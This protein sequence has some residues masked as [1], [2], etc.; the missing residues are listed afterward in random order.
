MP[1]P[2]ARDLVGLRQPGGNPNTSDNNDD[3]S[4]ELGR[5]LIVELGK[6][7]D[8]VGPPDAP[9][10]LAGLTI[11]HLR[12]IRP[13]LIVRDGS[14]LGYAQY[15]HLAVY[16]EFRRKW[17]G[18]RM[19]LAE[20]ETTASRLPPSLDRARME[21]ALSKARASLEEQARLV[22]VLADQ[23]PQESL[24]KLDIAVGEPV[25]EGL[26][27]LHVGLSAKWSLRT[28]RGQDPLS[29][30]SKLVGLRRGRMP[31]F[32]VLTIE[33]R[34]AMLKLLA[35]GSGSIDCIYHLDLAALSRTIETCSAS[36]A[37]PRRWSPKVTFDRLVRQGRIRDYDDLVREVLRIPTIEPGLQATASSP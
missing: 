11:E 32:A 20:L 21:A 17:T 7:A 23:M 8:T 12:T 33:P 18:P 37:D 14:A 4:I 31:H 35:D 26:P 16:P 25:G 29:Q 2:F 24:L 27:L 36:K 10:L 1:A 13:D 15:G 34:P 19:V 22:D 5:T 28:D 30:G 3:Q 9:R 6:P